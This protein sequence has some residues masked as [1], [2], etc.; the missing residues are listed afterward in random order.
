MNQLSV[1][2]AVKLANGC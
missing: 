1:T 2:F